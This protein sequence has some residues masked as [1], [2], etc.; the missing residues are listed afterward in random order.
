[1]MLI[2][3]L[4]FLDSLFNSMI[5]PAVGSIYRRRTLGFM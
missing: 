3:D 1:M 5:S 4:I 2:P